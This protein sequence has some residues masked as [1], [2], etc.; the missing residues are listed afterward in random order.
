MCN[1]NCNGVI[2]V[3]LP[4]FKSVN[5]SD[6]KLIV[7]YQKVKKEKEAIDAERAKFAKKGKL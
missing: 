5:N 4:K 6:Y 2:A 7:M 1:W 3:S